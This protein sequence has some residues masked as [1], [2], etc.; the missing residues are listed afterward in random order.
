MVDRVRTAPTSRL[1]VQSQCVGG[2]DN[3]FFNIESQYDSHFVKWSIRSHRLERR[4][5]IVGRRWSHWNVGGSSGRDGRRC[6]HNG[7]EQCRRRQFQRRNV[8]GGGGGGVGGKAAR[9]RDG[10]HGPP[11][12]RGTRKA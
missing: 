12:S 5:R 6:C 3:R 1:L 11:L 4:R 2:D 10:A 8:G 9:G 7:F